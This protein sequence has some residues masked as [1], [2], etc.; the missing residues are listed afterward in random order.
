MSARRQFYALYLARFAAFL[1]LVALNGL[2][3]VADSVREPASMALFADEG[4]DGDGVASS[5]G[6]RELV[7]RPGS[8][9]A[10]LLGGWAW[11]AYGM[12]SVFYLG[13][14]SAVL[15]ALLFLV[16]LASSHGPRAL[17]EW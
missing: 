15:A 8:V 17:T 9:L 6:V 12:D 1:P 3:G 2:L 14:A 16:V 4:S 13:G 11:S 5:F 10:P 7:W